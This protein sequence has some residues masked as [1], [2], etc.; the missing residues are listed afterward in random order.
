[1]AS[2]PFTILD[3]WEFL[4]ALLVQLVWDLDAQMVQISSHLLQPTDYQYMRAQCTKQHQ[5]VDATLLLFGMVQLTKIA[6]SWVSGLL[7]SS[8]TRGT[9]NTMGS[10]RFSSS[11]WGQAEFQEEGNVSVSGGLHM[12]R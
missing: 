7:A 4:Q 11:A 1:M 12:G 8:F 3:P 5:E 9:S 10:R 2:K 6:S